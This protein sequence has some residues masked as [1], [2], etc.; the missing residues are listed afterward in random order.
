MR[1]AEG[2]VGD[3]NA[4]ADGSVR[5]PAALGHGDVGVGQGRAA[6]D[7]ED[8][9][10]ERQELASCSSRSDGAGAG[11]F[12]LLGALAIAEVEGVG[13]MLAR[14]DGGADGGVHAAG[15]ADDGARTG[16]VGASTRVVRSFPSHSDAGTGRKATGWLAARADAPAAR[17]CSVRSPL[18]AHV[19]WRAGGTRRFVMSDMR[20]MRSPKSMKARCGSVWRRV[21]ADGVSYFQAL[22]ALD[23][24]AF[25]RR[26]EDPDV[27]AL[28]AGS[29][30]DAV[31][32][33]ADAAGERH[34]RGA[35][36]HGALD[37]LTGGSCRLQCIAMAVSSSSV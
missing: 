8:V 19:C 3:G 34:G 26:I 30:D 12:A 14:G 9:D 6:D 21:T 28:L 22:I 27:D 25:D 33:L 23:H 24:P 7:A 32:D 2:H 15:E 11:Q 18:V 37:F 29:G 16:A 4:A 10:G 13:L 17:I 36:A 1:V 31:K 35:L 20:L 5:R